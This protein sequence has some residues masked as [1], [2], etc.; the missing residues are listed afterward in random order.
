MRSR[1]S[2]QPG[3]RTSSTVSVTVPLS[4]GF[5]RDL[6]RKGFAEQN[7]HDREMIGRALALAAQVA[8]KLTRDRDEA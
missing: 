7:A 1:A 5:V 2:F 3:H 6:R 8:L 4:R